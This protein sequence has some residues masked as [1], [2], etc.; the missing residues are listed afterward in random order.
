MTHISGGSHPLDQQE[1]AIRDDER[2]KVRQEFLARTAKVIEEGEPSTCSQV[3]LRDLDEA[4][5]EQLRAEIARLDLRLRWTHDHLDGQI[6]GGLVFARD[7]GKRHEQQLADLKL[8]L[9]EV[10]A[11]RQSLRQRLA[12]ATQRAERAEAVVKAAQTARR[13]IGSCDDE[14]ALH[15][16]LEAYEVG[17]TPA[18][19]LAVREAGI[20]SDWDSPEDAVYDD[21]VEGA[22]VAIEPKRLPQMVSFRLDPDVAAGLRDI[23]NARGVTVSDLLRQGATQVRTASLDADLADIN[24]RAAADQR[25]LDAAEAWFDA[26]TQADQFGDPSS[27]PSYANQ[28]RSA[29]DARRALADTTEAAP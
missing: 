28:L 10:E 9:S 27:W 18:R 17:T 2:E 19:D 20:W 3:Q 11:D 26:V 15:A 13:Y 5:P 29:V 1:Q 24:R 6:W 4:T 7:M 16:A 12:E 22:G 14:L 25:V 21:V 8:A 23:A